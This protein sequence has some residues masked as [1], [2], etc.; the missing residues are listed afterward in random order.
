MTTT[1][2][3]MHDDI[4]L[5]FFF[6]QFK[7]QREAVN[8]VNTIVRM[9]ICSDTSVMHNVHSQWIQK[10]I[11]LKCDLAFDDFGKVSVLH[12]QQ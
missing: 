6:C 10:K 7:Q 5:F 3:V 8:N 4:T 12:N 1:K 2:G 9:Y 11:F